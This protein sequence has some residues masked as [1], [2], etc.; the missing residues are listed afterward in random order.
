MI[1]VSVSQLLASY[2]KTLLPAPTVNV[3]ED[4]KM[5]YFVL[6]PTRM[7]LLLIPIKC[8]PRSEISIAPYSVREVSSEC[9][10]P[11]QD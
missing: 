5:Y 2:V 7:T 10:V 4:A 9:V 8:T 11:L 6:L 3:R 1:R